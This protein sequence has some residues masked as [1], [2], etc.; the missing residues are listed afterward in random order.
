MMFSASFSTTSDGGEDCQLPVEF[1]KLCRWQISLRNLKNDLWNLVCTQIAVAHA[2]C[3]PVQCNPPPLQESTTLNTLEPV[4][5]PCKAA[6]VGFQLESSPVRI[7]S[8]AGN[9]A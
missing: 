5:H 2:P 6:E 4:H 7:P 9:K 3:V 1:G 8:G